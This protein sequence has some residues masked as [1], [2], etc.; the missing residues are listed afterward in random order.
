M[1]ITLPSTITPISRGLEET[2]S[3]IVIQRGEWGPLDEQRKLQI[4]R[5]IQ[6]LDVSLA[7]AESLH[8]AALRKK[9]I[10]SCHLLW[11]RI[12]TI[13]WRYARGDDL[14]ALSRQFDFPPVQVFRTLL[15]H[16]GWNK[17]RIKVSSTASHT[18]QACTILPYVLSRAQM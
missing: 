18:M 16:N 2:I 5:S 6:G 13:A 15:E 8:A 14:L 3:E 10:R 17:L 9:V 1:T 12:D 7:L 4:E 11:R